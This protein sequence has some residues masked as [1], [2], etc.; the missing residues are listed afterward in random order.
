MGLGLSGCGN[1]VDGF[2]ESNTST[3]IEKIGIEIDCTAPATLSDY[4]ELKSGDKIV[5][6]EEGSI[7]KLYHDENN[8]KRVCVQSGTAH[9]ERPI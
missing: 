4:I 6:D 2:K 5:K 1:N 7:I 8:L 3:P 9:I